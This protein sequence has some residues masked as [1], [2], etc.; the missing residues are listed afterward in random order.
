MPK[1]IFLP[2]VNLCA[3][4]VGQEHF[5]QMM[6]HLIASTVAPELTPTRLANLCV[7]N[8]MLVFTQQVE[9]V[10]VAPARQVSIP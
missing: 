4:L 5:K 7:R 6:V 10:Y 2:Q 9:R 8:V 1:A 3:L